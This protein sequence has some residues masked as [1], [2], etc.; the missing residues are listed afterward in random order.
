MIKNFYRVLALFFAFFHLA[1]CAETVVNKAKVYHD[2]TTEISFRGWG[3]KGLGGVVGK[4]KIT[5]ITPFSNLKGDIVILRWPNDSD[6][7][8]SEVY[9]ADSD[10]DKPDAW[11]LVSGERNKTLT[12][13][14]GQY[15]LIL[16]MLPGKD[17]GQKT[18]R[19]VLSE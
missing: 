13:Q 18:E 1:A 4:D 3:E 11:S 19:F 6:Y 9:R 15:F 16:E 5:V 17:G 7:F 12:D 14:H 2:V 10:K 8:Y